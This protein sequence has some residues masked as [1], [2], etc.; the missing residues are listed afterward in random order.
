MVAFPL[1]TSPEQA[2]PRRSLS[3]AKNKAK[4]S[5]AQLALGN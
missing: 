5:A 1:P 3:E 2:P 4:L